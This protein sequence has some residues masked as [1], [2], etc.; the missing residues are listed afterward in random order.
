MIK[1]GSQTMLD[2]NPAAEFLQELFVPEIT[3][4]RFGVAHATP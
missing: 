2:G 1:N 3:I 4:A